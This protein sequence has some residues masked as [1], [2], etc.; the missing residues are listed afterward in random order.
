V[1]CEAQYE[2]VSRL[3]GTSFAQFSKKDAA[4]AVAA[5]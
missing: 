5:D 2:L 3:K 4:L 1:W